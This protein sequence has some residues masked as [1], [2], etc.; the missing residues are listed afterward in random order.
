MT[1]DTTQLRRWMYHLVIAIAFA[2][3]CGRIASVQRVFE[4]GFH[5]DPDKADDRRPIWPSARPDVNPMFGSNDRARFAT[6]RSLVHDGTY[7]IGKRNETVG[8]MTVEVIDATRNAQV[9]TGVYETIVSES[10]ASDAD[11]Q[12]LTDAILAKY[13]VSGK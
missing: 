1:S 9:W 2:I 12:K 3:A 13:P 8:A 6:M 11:V 7:V 4:P 5:R 10:G